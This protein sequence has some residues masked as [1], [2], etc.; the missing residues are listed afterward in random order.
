VGSSVG[1]G[2]GVRGFEVS[3]GTAAAAGASVTTV[4]GVG[5]LQ[6]DITSARI[7]NRAK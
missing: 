7:N 6:P 1:S 2:V 3:A 4:A 5:V